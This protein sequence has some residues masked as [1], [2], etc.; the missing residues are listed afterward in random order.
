LPAGA[1]VVAVARTSPGGRAHRYPKEGGTR[2]SPLNLTDSDGIARLGARCTNATASSTSSSQCGVAGPS[3]PLGHIDLKPWNDVMAV[4][5]TRQL[6]AD[7][8]HGAA[9]ETI[10]R[11]PRRV[12]HLAAS[13][14][15]LAYVVPTPPRRPHSK[16]WCGYGRMKTASTPIRVS[17]FSPGRIRTRMRATVFSRRRPDDAGHARAGRRIIA[18]HVCASLDRDGKVYDYKTRTLLS[19]RAPA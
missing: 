14:L 13:H 18:A 19:F 17:L 3:S 8:L 10:R 4:N 7:P 5:V 15:A 16:R 2:P 12:H 11:R 6:P 9:V 1:H